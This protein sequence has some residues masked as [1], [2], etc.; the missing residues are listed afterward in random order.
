MSVK[1]I[2]FNTWQRQ[3][4]AL[5][6]EH[7][8]YAALRKSVKEKPTELL[9]RINNIK[10]LSWSLSGFL[11]HHQNSIHHLKSGEINDQIS[12]NGGFLSFSVQ[13]STTWVTCLPF[14]VFH[15]ERGAIFPEL[16][17]PVL[18]S[19]MI[20]YNPAIHE[21]Q[22]CL[23]HAIFSSEA[24]G[25]QTPMLWT[26]STPPIF[27]FWWIIVVQAW[28]LV[29][30]IQGGRVPG[31]LPYLNLPEQKDSYSRGTIWIS[32]MVTMFTAAP[33]LSSSYYYNLMMLRWSWPLAIKC[34]HF[35]TKK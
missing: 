21:Y 35:V 13:I 32:V 11:C 4:E 24:V 29:L 1:Y 33:E 20:E 18:R 28:L 2:C 17:G 34:H 16:S 7:S 10:Q 26:N 15:Y 19:C 6:A 31:K 9:R 30:S 22:F 5:S 8:C 25:Q 27:S 14:F 12:H 3:S 23:T